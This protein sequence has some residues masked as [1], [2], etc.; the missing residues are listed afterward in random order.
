VAGT[1]I[2]TTTSEYDAAGHARG[3][4]ESYFILPANNTEKDL[5]SI[6]SRVEN[7][8]NTYIAEDEFDDLASTYLSTN[9]YVQEEGFD[10][11]V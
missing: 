4:S 11:K 3:S 8:E 1:I 10:E 6:T 7:L 9:Q 5:T 2:K